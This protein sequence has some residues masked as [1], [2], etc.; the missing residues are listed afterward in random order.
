MARYLSV[1]F[2]TIILTNI[3]VSVPEVSAEIP[4][5]LR[6]IDIKPHSD[7]TRLI[8]QLDR[9]T[10]FSVT[11][12]PGNRFKISL[13][14]TSS[15]LFQKLRSY[16]NQHVKGISVARRG[17]ELQ[18]IIGKSS[19]EMGF[20]VVARDTGAITLDVGPRFRA[21]R[22]VPVVVAGREPIWAGAGR[23]VKEYA[24]PIRS[25]LPFVPTDKKALL[26]LLTA[27]EANLFLVGEAAIYKGQSSDAVG[28]F[29]AF[30]EKDSGISAL[31]AYRCGQ[32]YYNL[33]EYESALK[34][35]R[36]GESLWPEF[37]ELS[38]DVKFAYA[39]C[40]VR[41][42]DLPAGRKL[43]AKLIASRADRNTAPV[44]LV[45]LADILARQQRDVESGIIY[46]NVVKFFPSNRAAVYASLKL[47]DR[48]FT[49]VDIV[50]YADLR[51]EYLRIAQ[52]SSDFQVREEAYFKAALLDAL[53]GTWQDALNSVTSYEKRYP[54]GVLASLARAMHID[55]MPAV[56][57]EIL[58]AWD[59]EQMTRVMDKNS[60]FLSK[61]ME[62]P[63]FV[64]ELDRAFTELGLM[65]DENR[66]F[67]NLVRRDW[68]NQHAPFLYG[69]ILE[70]SVSLADWQLAESTGREFIQKFPGLPQTR[71]AREILGDVGYRKGDLKAVR[72]DLAFLLDPKVRAGTSESYYYLGKSLE[73]AGEM[74][75]AGKAMELFL[76]SAQGP[77][78]LSPL[79]ADAYF[80]VGTSY[81][82]GKNR[83]K[84]M[85]AFNSGLGK[86]PQDGRDRFLFRIGEIHKSSGRSAEAKKSWEMI[87]KEGSDQIWQKL[88]SQELSDLEWKTRT[89]SGI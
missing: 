41:S 89:G 71:R 26:P 40:L 14:Q 1:I 30:I 52:A 55:L 47:A 9:E 78:L 34:M 4:S 7:Y 32:A 74:K 88:A 60:D 66:L 36:K 49:E 11:D 29:N 54:R 38:P 64:V 21:D 77:Q 67:G 69:K 8:L 58:N 2:F 68:A 20:R 25:E 53:F 45:R 84:A 28:I 5:R 51:V 18:V 43:L 42:G 35:F 48:R 81:L 24:P 10:T 57:R 15:P 83:E 61:C 86:A 17:D 39:D 75:Q 80:V 13:S 76:S 70:N 46:S 6:R 62:D 44:L 22:S 16:S 3:F 23:F 33:L 72:T 79:V 50:N 37:L 27:D 31:A 59:P 12:L 63:A 73:A 82:S 87:V 65:K 56:Y 85:A 19:P